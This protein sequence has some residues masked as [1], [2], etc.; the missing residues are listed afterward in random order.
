MAELVKPCLRWPC[1]AIRLS[2]AEGYSFKA[3]CIEADWRIC[4][5]TEGGNKVEAKQS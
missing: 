5:L 3:I 2:Q 4:P 1:P